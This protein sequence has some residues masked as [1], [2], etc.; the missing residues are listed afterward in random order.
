MKT[1]ESP[2]SALIACGLVALIF[3]LGFTVLAVRL[4]EEQVDN[5]AVR[6]FEMERQSKRRVQTAGIR[7]RILA[8]HG[9]VLACN[10]PASS[11]VLNAEAFAKK[12]WSGT[13]AEIT[14]AIARAE[15][16]LGR[17]SPLTIRDIARHLTNEVS[18]PLVVWRN[19]DEDTLARFAEHE[20]DLP[21]FDYEE[22]LERHYPQGLLAAHLLGYVGR[23]HAKTEAGD[24]KFHFKENELSGRTGL[25]SY[26]NSFLRGMPGESE[27]LVDARGFRRAERTIVEPCAGPDLRL[28]LD[29]PIQRE[30]ERQLRGH[31][32]ACVVLDPRDGSVLAMA[33][34]P[35]FDPNEF[36]PVLKA[37]LYARY[38]KDSRKPLLNRACAEGYAPGSTFKPIT[39]LAGLSV[40]LNPAE[41]Y[42]CTGAYYLGKFRI[43]CARTWGHGELDLRTA[44]KESCNAYFCR[45]G[46]MAGT[47]AVMTMARTFGLGSATGLDF[48]S[49]Y[50]GIVPDDTWKRNTYSERWYP[51]D[52]AQMSIGQGMLLVTPLQMARVIGALGTGRLVRP[53]LKEGLSF[54]SVPLSVP[55]DHLATVRQGLR[56]VV[57]RTGTGHRGA[58]G[59]EAEVMGKTGTAELGRGATRRKNTWF[60]AY[61]KGTEASRP[62]AQDREVAIA[63]VIERGES[64]GGT[65]AP[66]V[67][68][69]LKTIFNRPPA[70]KGGAE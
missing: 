51:G 30:V 2:F 48:V 4:R 32:G 38:L 49:D 31:C 52:L 1:E 11:I 46:C 26:Y 5:T 56:A 57:S 61:A 69:V 15:K 36:V 27:L 12:S 54:D 60:V 44:L 67:C 37:D 58:D 68:A 18:R 10:V 14:N 3:V 16:V 6:T 40:G 28:T 13:A 25:E 41:E 35:T 8:R 70:E 42:E 24:R 59:V 65:T 22:R 20:L 55:K 47:N 21:G 9:E 63:M 19:V 33:S 23:E 34:A 53:H 45:T 17:K 29:L 39:A 62:D 50:R 43:R 66:K 7:G 64:G